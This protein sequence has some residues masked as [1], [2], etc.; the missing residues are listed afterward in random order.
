MQETAI[1][2]A[3][4]ELEITEGMLIGDMNSY[5]QED[6]VIAFASGGYADQIGR[7]RGLVDAGVQTAIVSF[8]DLGDLEPIGL[9]RADRVSEATCDE[10]TA[11]PGG[12]ERVSARSPS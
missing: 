6:P 3:C 2:P 4:L 12:G 10:R 9:N 7:F 11:A 1:P 8:P 5:A